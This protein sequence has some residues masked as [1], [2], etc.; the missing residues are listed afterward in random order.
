[1]RLLNLTLALPFCYRRGYFHF[2]IASHFALFYCR[3]NQN[4]IKKPSIERVSSVFMF[5]YGQK[6][7]DMLHFA[8]Q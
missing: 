8:L 5:D 4:L 3:W 1:M 7:D 6:V 2:S